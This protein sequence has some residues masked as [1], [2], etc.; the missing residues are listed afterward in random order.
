MST[1][2]PG[3]VQ[4]A[5]ATAAIS[6]ARLPSGEPATAASPGPEGSAD[7][8]LT[9]SGILRAAANYGDGEGDDDE[10]HHAV[11]RLLGSC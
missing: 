2:I 8:P 3:P 6:G 1:S 9:D 7:E 4:L 10:G 11:L 5:P